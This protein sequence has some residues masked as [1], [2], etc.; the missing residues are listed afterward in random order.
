MRRQRR[1]DASLCPRCHPPGPPE[2]YTPKTHL[3]YAE[4]TRFR[5]SIL[6]RNAALTNALTLDA[7]RRPNK[8]RYPTFAVLATLSAEAGGD[9]AAN[10][11]ILG[12]WPLRRATSRGYSATSRGRARGNAAT[13]AEALGR[14]P[15]APR[16]G[17]AGRHRKGRRRAPV[18][19]DGLRRAVRSRPAPVRPQAASRRGPSRAA[20][21]RRL[22]AP[23]TRSRARSAW[24]ASSPRRGSRR[25]GT[26]SGVSPDA[27]PLGKTVTPASR[28]G[29]T[30]PTRAG[31][32]TLK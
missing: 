19:R 8:Q 4:N 12:G 25:R 18:P 26:C 11:A 10:G 13:S 30:R 32:R 21:R 27:D 20:Q 24:P 7:Q 5:L 17:R 1:L 22:T 28:M 23:P 31:D 2:R 15:G 6:R 29:V 9:D 16:R 14:P 3:S